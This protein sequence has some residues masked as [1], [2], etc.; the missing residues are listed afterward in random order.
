MGS[1]LPVEGLCLLK[2]NCRRISNV[3]DELKNRELKHRPAGTRGEYQT[4]DHLFPQRA[5]CGA[6][7]PDRRCRR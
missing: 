3:S 2:G 1:D 4:P 7:F 5:N 6:K